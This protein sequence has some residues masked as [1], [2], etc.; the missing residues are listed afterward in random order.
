MSP[1]EKLCLE[2][3][4]EEEMVL[5]DLDNLWP[6]WDSTAQVLHGDG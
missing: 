5:N 2:N 1:E 3:N 4:N 6:C